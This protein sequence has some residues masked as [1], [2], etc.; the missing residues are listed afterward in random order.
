M[1]P[2]A[3]QVP[4]FG[5]ADLSNCEREPIHL[6]G[7]I[8]P[9]GALIVI[10]GLAG[11]IV[12]ASAN[13]KA[14]LNQS[15]EV[16][17]RRLADLG[18]NLSSRVKSHLTPSLETLPVS[19]R[20]RVGTPERELDTLMHRF[21]DGHIVVEF[22]EAGAPFDSSRQVDRA[23]KAILGATSLR[24]LCDE[25]ARFFKEIAGYDRVM[26]YRFDD[27]GHGE[28]FAERRKPRLE[29]FPRQL[30]SRLRY[31]ADRPPALR[32]QPGA[33]RRRCR[34]QPGAT[35]ACA[36]ADH[37]RRTR[38]V[39]LL[40]A[41]HVADPRPVPEEHGR[42]RNPR[43]LL[44]GRWPA[45]GSRLLPSLRAADGSLRHS[46]HLRTAG[47]G[48]RHPHFGAG[49]LL[50]RPVGTVRPPPRAT[51]DGGDRATRRMARGA[52]RSIDRPAGAVEGDGR[53]TAVRRPGAHR[54]RRSGDPKPARDRQPG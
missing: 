39:A 12:Q 17:G 27:E 23:L 52:V 38:H 30:V 4:A 9:H 24:T 48:G 21:A 3:A 18:G 5:Q 1:D 45:M 50:A 32:A 31:S 47:R 51:H 7:S 29:P 36:T 22:E 15:K 35:G 28:V 54:R 53:G 42:R 11:P 33:D 43:G 19:F 20:C 44:D 46:R 37:R 25:T 26:V 41:Q 6:A 34:I 8:Q 13:A 40:S 49:E 14:F 10:E 16:H 2:R